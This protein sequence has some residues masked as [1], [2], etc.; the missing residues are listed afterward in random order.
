ML[1]AVNNACS[2]FQDAVVCCVT[3]KA[4]VPHSE[5]IKTSITKIVIIKMIAIRQSQPFLSMQ[6]KFLISQIFQPVC[7]F[8]IGATLFFY[9][10]AVF[11]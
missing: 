11:E 4:C 5:Y 7:P 2:H 6:L 8:C 10:W 9:S 3:K 1:P